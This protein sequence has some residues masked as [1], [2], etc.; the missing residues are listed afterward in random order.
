MTTK[1]TLK[2]LKA[3]VL[4]EWSPTFWLVNRKTAHREAHYDVV[5]VAID[6]K[7][8]KRLRG[9]VKAQIQ[10][11]DYHLEAYDH[12]NADTEEVLL[13]LD[14][15]GTDFIDVEKAIAEGFNNP[16]AQQ[17][18]EL[19]NG[20]AY[21]VQFTKG[22]DNLYAWRKITGLTDPKKVVSKNATFFNNHRLEDIDDKQVFM[23]DPQF[24][25]FVFGGV[26]FI[27]NKR[28]FETSMNFREGMKANG[29]ALLEEF[30]GMSF[31]SDVEPIRQHVGD[32]LNH[33]RKLAA[34]KKAG[35]YLQPDYVQELMHVCQQQGWDLKIAGGKIV[36]EEETIDVLLTL[37]N[38]G[39]LQSPI[40]KEWFDA[41]V[42]RAVPAKGAGC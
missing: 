2:K 33:L 41:A 4:G 37:L 18:E 21:V 27:A 11:R 30:K 7:L 34:I 16:L 9:Y 42:K 26:S 12:T 5:R 36:V 28:L 38:N 25:F 29:D 19:L 31:L 32:N 22:A 6:K 13:T 14:V 35:Y 3:L 17:Y 24:D 8:E 15:A 39:R 20:W 23:I 1:N 10:D 40:N